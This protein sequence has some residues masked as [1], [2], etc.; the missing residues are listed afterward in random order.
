MDEIQV[1]ERML[2]SAGALAVLVV[3]AW[4]MPLLVDAV[5]RSQERLQEMHVQLVREC[6]LRRES[7]ERALALSRLIHQERELRRAAG[8]ER[9]ELPRPGPG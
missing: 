2:S 4:R 6:C 5:L 9:E 3:L 8:A 1:L 7:Q